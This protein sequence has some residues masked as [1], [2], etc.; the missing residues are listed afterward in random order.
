VQTFKQELL[1]WA[2]KLPEDCDLA[3]VEQF[4]YVR[5]EVNAGIAD[6]EAGR[7]VSQEDVK[8][9]SAEWLKSFGPAAR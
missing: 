5:R 7:V 2:A 4:V 3:D 1:A 8:R 6:V 9:E